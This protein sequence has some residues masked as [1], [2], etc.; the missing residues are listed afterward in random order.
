VQVEETQNHAAFI[1]EYLA[2][3]RERDLPHCLKYYDDGATINFVVGMYQGKSAIEQWHNDRFQAELEVLD[4]PRFDVQGDTVVVMGSVT[5]KRLRK[6][7]INSL[8]AKATFLI[9]SGKIKELKFDL[10]VSN[11]LEAWE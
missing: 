8:G 9:E 2:A 10:A 6:W 1:N 3:F 7:R 4:T 5:S 11:P